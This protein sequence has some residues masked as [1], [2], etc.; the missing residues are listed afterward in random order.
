LAFAVAEDRFS[1]ASAELERWIQSRVLVLGIRRIQYRVRD[2]FEPES[3][4]RDIWSQHR[5]VLGLI[6]SS[7]KEVDGAGPRL[8]AALRRTNSFVALA[9]QP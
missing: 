1:R 7:A 9:V 5:S 6:G 4:L 3:I 2:N 8:N